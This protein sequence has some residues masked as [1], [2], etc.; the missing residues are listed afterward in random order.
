[1]GTPTSAATTA[2]A[3]TSTSVWGNMRAM[4]SLTGYPWRSELPKSKRTERQ[5]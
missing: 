3:R 4:Y 2:L 5:R 1:M